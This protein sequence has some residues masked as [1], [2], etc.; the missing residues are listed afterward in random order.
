MSL[1]PVV[2]E[3]VYTCFNFTVELVLGLTLGFKV[4]Q[5][6]QRA[7]QTII[8]ANNNDVFPKFFIIKEIKN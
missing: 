7:L 6:K 4:L 1:P 8:I 3:E 5:L 2:T